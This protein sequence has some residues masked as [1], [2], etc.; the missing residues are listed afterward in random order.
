MARSALFAGAVLVLALAPGTSHSDVASTTNGSSEREFHP[1]NEPYSLG[2]GA[3]SYEQLS[4]S[5]QSAVMAV[6]QS[7]DLAQSPDSFAAWSA[8]T[9]AAGDSVEATLAAQAVGLVGA[10]DEGVVE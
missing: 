1:P 3:I 9:A 6:Q 4:T 5:Q 2:P 10:A 7:T 8:A